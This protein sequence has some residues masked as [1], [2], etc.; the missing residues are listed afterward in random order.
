MN[1]QSS[2]TETVEG[3]IMEIVLVLTFI[4]GA[5]FVIVKE[6]KCSKGVDRSRDSL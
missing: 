4:I 5:V 6:K 2:I 3:Y 1:S